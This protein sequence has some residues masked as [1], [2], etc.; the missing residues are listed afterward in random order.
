MFVCFFHC[1][2]VQHIVL[3]I[4]TDDNHLPEKIKKKRKTTEK[5]T[6]LF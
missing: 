6:I 3:E 2:I 4:Q 1:I 5:G